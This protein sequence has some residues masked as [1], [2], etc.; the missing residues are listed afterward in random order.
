MSEWFMNHSHLDSTLAK[1]FTQP[2][3]GFLF[4]PACASSRC[5][6]K[7]KRATGRN[8][9]WR[10]R[11]SC[12]EPRSARRSPRSTR[13]PT[14]TEGNWV[15]SCFSSGSECGST[16]GWSSSVGRKPQA[17]TRTVEKRPL[18]ARILCVFIGGEADNSSIGKLSFFI[19]RRFKRRPNLSKQTL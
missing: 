3:A 13:T 15:K 11:N 17:T 4:N 9:L 8:W 5:S 18:H 19:L 1:L 14:S 16:S 12:T 10:R 7:R 6:V 2:V